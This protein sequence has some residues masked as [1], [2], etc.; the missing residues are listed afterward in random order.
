[1]IPLILILLGI[2]CE[3]VKANMWFVIPEY[4]SYILFGLG[5]L[6]LIVNT[7]NF[8]IAKSRFNKLSSKINKKFD[9]W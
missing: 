5:G 3:I 6:M 4:V 9:R 2:A 1:M 8:M 7:I